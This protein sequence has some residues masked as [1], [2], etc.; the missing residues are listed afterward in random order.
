MNSDKKMAFYVSSSPF[1]AIHGVPAA[2][3]IPTKTPI[4][5]FGHVGPIGIVGSGI[6]IS[7]VS[8]LHPAMGI[9]HPGLIQA[10]LPPPPTVY[11]SPMP[12]GV[13]YADH[14]RSSN[15]HPVHARAVI[16]SI[17]DRKFG[18]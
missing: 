3:V 7:H 6:H 13:V 15:V 1:V 18:K 4:D 2:M 5:T 14:H 10:L 17:I 9:T 16:N 11:A 12:M 8:G